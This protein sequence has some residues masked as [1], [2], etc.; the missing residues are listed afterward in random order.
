MS[1]RAVTDHFI[2]GKAPGKDRDNPVRETS[3][4]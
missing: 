1:D 4:S 2:N 3:M